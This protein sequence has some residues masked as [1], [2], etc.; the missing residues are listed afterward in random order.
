MIT[1]AR[2]KRGWGRGAKLSTHSAIIEMNMY[3]KHYNNVQPFLIKQFVKKK[4]AMSVIIIIR[5]ATHNFVCV[6]LAPIKNKLLGTKRLFGTVCEKTRSEIIS[7]FDEKV[8]S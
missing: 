2:G 6:I 8:K 5:R 7:K 4:N 1:R 3:T